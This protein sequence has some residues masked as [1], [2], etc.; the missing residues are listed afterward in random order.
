MQA[1]KNAAISAKILANMNNGM[2][3]PEAFDAVMGAGAY[4]NLAGEVYS[5]LRKA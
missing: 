2:T 5:E 4:M 1:L 3:L